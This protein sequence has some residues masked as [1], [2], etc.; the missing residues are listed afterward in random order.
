MIKS[1]KPG[2]GTY[3]VREVD[4]I[5]E[6]TL[7]Q[8]NGPV[9]LIQISKSCNNILVSEDIKLQTIYYEVVHVI[10]DDLGYYELSS[11]E[12]FVQSFECLLHQ[13]EKTKK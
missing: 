9:G 12:T 7:C 4:F 13:F 10:L 5:N 8:L 11:D 6:S 3:K 1:F 2:V